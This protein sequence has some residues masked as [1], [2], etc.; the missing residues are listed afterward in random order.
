ML[1]EKINQWKFYH[2]VITLNYFTEVAAGL[3]IE[4]KEKPKCLGVKSL[5]HVKCC[6]MS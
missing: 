1:L 6:N 4:N 3:L 2:M 5:P